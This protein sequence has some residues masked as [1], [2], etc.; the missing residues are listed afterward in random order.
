MPPSGHAD[1]P[2]RGVAAASLRARR[3]ARNLLLLQGRAV[4]LVVQ[5]VVRPQNPETD[6][7]AEP[8]LAARVV[9]MQQLPLKLVA[10]GHRRE[11]LVEEGVV[12]RDAVHQRVEVVDELVRPLEGRAGKRHRAQ[13]DGRDLQPC[14]THHLEAIRPGPRGSQ[15]LELLRVFG[16][17]ARALPRQLVGEARRRHGEGKRRL[18]D[19]SRQDQERSGAQR[20]S[21]AR[22]GGR[23]PDSE[24]ERLLAASLAFSP[25]P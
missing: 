23:N 6:R 2:M 20:S 12:E 10:L 16:R 7:L 13:A 3:G 25:F 17:N 22:A 21:D 15:R 18:Q 8:L 9:D 19:H 4:A 24:L 11:V 5:H 1:L 14:R